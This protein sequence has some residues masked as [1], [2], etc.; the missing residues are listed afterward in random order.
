MRSVTRRDWL[1]AVASGS[2]LL[3]LGRAGFASRVSLRGPTP[4]RIGTNM[5][6]SGLSIEEALRK[7]RALGFETVE[8]KGWGVPDPGRGDSPGFQ[9]EKLSADRRASIKREL[10]AFKHVSIHLPFAGITVVNSNA[11]EQARGRRVMEASLEGA[12]YFEV[13]TANIHLIP[14]RGI[15]LGD[16]WDELVELYRR[17]GDMAQKGGFKLAVETGYPP[18]VRQFLQFLRDV[19][20][21]FVGGSID[22]GHQIWYEEFKSRFDGKI[23]NTPEAIRIYNDILE[24]LVDGLGDKLFH[25]HVHDIDPSVWKEHKPLKYGVI[26]YVRLFKKLIELDYTGLL[27]FEISGPD[28]TEN[29]VE[30]RQKLLAALDTARQE[31]SA[32]SESPA[33]AR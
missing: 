4:D 26:D 17:W 28:V 11:A 7:T 23:P 33:A 21:P 14:P 24:Q 10:R 12:A 6:F 25:F 19:D 15:S 32:A 2:V 16:C 3:A 13:E 9:F 29:L 20:H 8:L 22:V 30:A 1:R 27:V 18:S 5:P 31:L